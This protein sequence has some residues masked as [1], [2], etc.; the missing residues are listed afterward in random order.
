MSDFFEQLQIFSSRVFDLLGFDE[1]TSPWQGKFR[2]GFPTGAVIHF[3]GSNEPE[4]SVSW[5]MR[6]KFQAK[7]SA[8]VVVYQNWPEN[9]KKLATDLPRVES[10][11]VAVVQCVPPYR[12]ANHAKWA[13]STY[14]GV[15]IV[16]AGEVRRADPGWVSWGKGWTTPWVSDVEPVYT[17]GRYWAPYRWGQL[18]TTM[19][20]LTYLSRSYGE[21]LS[22]FTIL[23]HENTDQRK[24]D[25]GPL[26]PLHDVRSEVMRGI[27]EGDL[28]GWA[29]AYMTNVSYCENTRKAIV[30]LGYGKVAEFMGEVQLQFSTGKAV[31]SLIK[32]VLALLGYYVTSI[33]L[34][35]QDEDLNSIRIFQRMMGLKVDGIPGRLTQQ[36]LLERL[37]SR[38]YFV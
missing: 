32:L 26:F 34:P 23:G 7:V 20:L 8:H 37:I 4:R 27:K 2:Y 11:P 16:N 36:G 15:E 10:L 17:G 6:E 30:R 29:N 1:K 18:M 22:A 5:F 24:F 33:N 38:N 31:S 21:C 28:C 25:P 9:Y 13:N 3:T 35:F 19:R 12:R 14:Y